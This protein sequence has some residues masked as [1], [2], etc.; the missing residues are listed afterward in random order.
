MTR[1]PITRR[2]GDPRTEPRIAGPRARRIWI[3]RAVF[4]ALAV[5]FLLVTWP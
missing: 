1:P 3:E 2:D 5:V 4:Y